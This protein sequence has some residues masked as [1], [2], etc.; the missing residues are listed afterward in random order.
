MARG[1]PFS[2]RLDEETEKYVVA[3]TL[4]TNRSKS[5]V[6]EALT[7]EAVR[8]R[9]F[10]GIAFRGDDARRRPWIIGT[11]LDV[12]EVVQM[13]EDYGSVESLVEET[14]LTA[15]QAR[16]AQAYRRAYPAEIAQAIAENRRS[17]E[18]FLGLYPFIEFVED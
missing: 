2:V 6:V 13:L 10:P 11:G 15:A 5:A 7:E 18:E 9:R 1:Q 17:P 16:L 4:R 12:W 14:Q 8:T 3:E